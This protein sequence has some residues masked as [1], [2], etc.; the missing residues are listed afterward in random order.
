MNIAS[1]TGTT[2][3]RVTFTT[4]MPDAN[5]SVVATQIAGGTGNRINSQDANGFNYSGTNSSGS[6]VDYSFNFTVFATNALPPKGGTGTDAWGVV[7]IDASLT[8][9]FNI[10]SVTR[11]ETGKSQVT[12]TTPMPTAN[13]AVTA[14]VTGGG[15]DIFCSI[16]N[17]TTAGFVVQTYE[18]SGTRYLDQGYGFSVNATNATLPQTVTQEQ[19]DS[20]INNPGCSAWGDVAADGSLLGGLNASTS[21]LSTG[22]YE[23]TFATPMPSANYAVLL[24]GLGE[25]CNVEYPISATGFSYRSQSGSLLQDLPTSFAVFSTNALP[26]KG[27]TGTDAWGTFDGTDGSLEGGFNVASVTRTNNGRYTVVFGTAM[28]SANYSVVASSSGT[29]G[30]HLGNVDVVSQSSA[31]F[32][33]KVAD[34]SN[35]TNDAARVNFAV[36]ATNATLPSTFTEAQI[37]K[38]LDFIDSGGQGGASAWG[39]IKADA[40]VLE[41]SNIASVTKTSTGKFDIVFTTPMSSPN[42]AV[43]TCIEY[44]GASNGSASVFGGSKTVNGFTMSLTSTSDQPYDYDFNFSVFSN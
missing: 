18:T 27:G 4:P 1:V 5:Y 33:L 3:K 42:F 16:I 31:G 43:T 37:Q 10:A 9:G 23:V 11:T 25:A 21:R 34:Q 44:P 6:A 36:N 24:S 26:P 12:F 2:N 13:Y 8:T 35:T 15:G 39:C 17:Q 7:A 29:T 22:I 28:P 40:T 32:D 38:V 30:N 14:S 41:H 19:I 20:A